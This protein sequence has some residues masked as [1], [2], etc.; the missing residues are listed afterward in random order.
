MFGAGAVA[1]CGPGA[2]GI[3]RQ[4]R[5]AAASRSATAGSADAHA[6]AR[7]EFLPP[8]PAAINGAILRAAAM[9][10]SPRTHVKNLEPQTRPRG[11]F[12]QRSN[13][14]GKEESGRRGSRPLGGNYRRV[15]QPE[16]GAAISASR[17]QDQPAAGERLSQPR[18]SCKYAYRALRRLWT[19]RFIS[20]STK[21]PASGERRMAARA[22]RDS[23]TQSSCDIPRERRGPGQ[24]RPR[25]CL[26][27]AAANI[28]VD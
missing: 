15:H 26:Q 7:V 16:E 10:A 27:I 4:L 9:P 28:R 8:V 6:P 22:V 25:P 1:P 20:Y 19:V 5:S 13:M 12:L 11:A 21:V 24:T 2:I 18:D 17:A 3:L 14:R 23:P